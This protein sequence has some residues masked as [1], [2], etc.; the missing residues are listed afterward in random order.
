MYECL[1]SNNGRWRGEAGNDCC[2][3][4]WCQRCYPRLSPVWFRSRSSF[5]IV[6][7]LQ[8]S[9][10]LRP[11][12]RNPS[13]RRRPPAFRLLRRSKTLEETKGAS[14][15]FVGSCWLLVKQ[16]ATQTG[17]RLN[18]L[19]YGDASFLSMGFSPHFYFLLLCV[20]F[21]SRS[22]FFRLIVVCRPSSQI[23][24]FI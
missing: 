11:A 14:R 5:P 12:E 24:A 20:N 7:V 23:F 15:Q 2:Y 10:T 3:C 21:S 8:K 22:M 9:K 13:V 16:R 4:S 1:C 19:G 18:A 6:D 17:T